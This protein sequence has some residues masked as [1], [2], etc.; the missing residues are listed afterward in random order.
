MADAR[1]GFPRW[2]R[3]G[4][5]GLL[6]SV[7][8]ERV[9][10]PLLGWVCRPLRVEGREHLAGVSAP[11]LLVAN[12]C[13]HLDT[14]VLLRA[15]PRHLRRRLAVAAAADYF[16]ERRGPA[17]LAPLLLHA[18]P[19]AR[20][21]AIRPSLDYCHELVAEGWAV[22]V[23]P[24]GTRSP[25]GKP[26]PFKAGVGALAVELGVPVIP[27]YLTGPHACLPRGASR[28]RPGPVTVRFGRPLRFR[29]RAPVPRVAAE[30]DA[31]VRALA[32]QSPAV[33]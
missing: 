33:A 14:I 2:A 3:S 22:L 5:A 19:L 7:F 24:E 17:L 1:Q 11:Y 28:P 12:H 8:Q 4:P 13:S 23:Y 18:F 27:A 25:D 32:G 29:R 30:L 6:R 16:F 31:A 10:L 15:L 26:R 9:L 21:G 20:H